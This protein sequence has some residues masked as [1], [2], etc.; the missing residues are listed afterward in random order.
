MYE[1]DLSKSFESFKEEIK[2][3]CSKSQQV[4]LSDVPSDNITK[5]KEN[6]TTCKPKENFIE[7]CREMPP[8][9]TNA[10]QFLINWKKYTSFDFRYRYLK[11]SNNFL[12]MKR[13]LN[14]NYI[15]IFLLANAAG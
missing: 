7:D 14:I 12:H 5:S 4:E 9:P 15:Q 10:V 13:Y 3:T 6:I 1:A 2:A 8:I 11:V